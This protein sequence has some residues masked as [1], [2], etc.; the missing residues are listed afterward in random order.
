MIKAYAATQPIRIGFCVPIASAL[1]SQ[2]FLRASDGDSVCEH[3]ITAITKNENKKKTTYI[4]L[5]QRF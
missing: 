1:N 3:K 5:W 4:C 2:K